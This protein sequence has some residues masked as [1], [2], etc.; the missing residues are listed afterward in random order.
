MI[1]ALIVIA[2]TLYSV[3]ISFSNIWKFVHGE[4]DL[5]KGSTENTTKYTNIHKHTPDAVNYFTTDA[6]Y[7]F[8][9]RFIYKS[10]TIE[11]QKASLR[12]QADT[13]DLRRHKHPDGRRT[14]IIYELYEVKLYVHRTG[15]IAVAFEK[16]N[17][18]K[19]NN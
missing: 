14:I 17:T 13:I 9:R 16:L 5:R 15:Q 11:L 19:I 6:S 2:A 4:H 12:T 3:Y 7:M 10:V 1:L 18:N 8:F